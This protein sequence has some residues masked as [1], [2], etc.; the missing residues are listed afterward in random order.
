MI[1]F[2]G[3]SII[4]RLALRDAAI[5]PASFTSIRLASGAVT[6]LLI[7][8]AMS[9]GDRLRRHGS[10]LSALMLFLYAICFSYAYV[11]LSAGTGALILF[12]TVQGT[13]IAA[14][15]IAGDRPAA[16]E[17][18]GWSAACAGLVW[19]L[20]PGIEAPPIVGS[21][22]MAI[23]GISWGIYSLRGRRES[24]A[25]AANASNFTLSVTMV[26]VLLTATHEVAEIS[27]RGIFLAVLSGTV[28]SGLGY[29]IW[30]RALEY[31]RAMQA[32]L[33]QL[34]VPAIAM[35]G[36]TLLLGEALTLR[37]IVS[38]ALVLGGISLALA[39]KTAS[40]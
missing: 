39:R 22:L 8:L 26:L 7:F 28:T 40:T 15:L 19:L 13:M 35:A 34:S 2:A 30:Y 24:N 9:R 1:A 38:T 25:L 18:L 36:G 21:G 17:W 14:G 32:A 29:V 16:L 31:L 23:A 27:A 3:N 11:S 12:G 33:V 5:D 4:C 6:L 20:L 10:W 37:L